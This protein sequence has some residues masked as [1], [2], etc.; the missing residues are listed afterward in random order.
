MSEILKYVTHAFPNVL[1]GPST[2]T[3]APLRWCSKSSS[4]WGTSTAAWIQ[5]STPVTAAP[6][7]W[8]SSKFWGAAAT[9]GDAPGG[10][11]GCTTTP[12]L[13]PASAPPH[14]GAPLG[15]CTQTTAGGSRPQFIEALAPALHWRPV[16]RMGLF[17]HWRP[18]PP[19]H[20]VIPQT[21]SR[22]SRELNSSQYR[23]ASRVE[24][25]HCFTLMYINS[26]CIFVLLHPPV[27]VCFQ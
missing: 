17:K 22:E 10:G 6:S 24:S 23:P 15:T 14:P 25:F 16:Q 20:Q 12:A 26:H 1:Q 8:P 13:S 4:G 5:S 21:T 3:S 7:S 19:P 27:S 9:K 11:D 18:S 2:A